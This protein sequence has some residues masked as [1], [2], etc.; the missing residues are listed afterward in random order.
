MLARPWVSLDWHVTVLVEWRQGVS[1]MWSFL[2]MLIHCGRTYWLAEICRR[3][4][5]RMCVLLKKS[6]P[7]IHILL[8]ANCCAIEPETVMLLSYQAHTDTLSSLS[9]VQTSNQSE[10]TFLNVDF[11]ICG[12]TASW[13]CVLRD[14]RYMS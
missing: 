1:S 11:S 7:G 9:M 4:N 8:S 12:Q 10:E 6:C 13:C 3:L 5:T 14:N 2:I